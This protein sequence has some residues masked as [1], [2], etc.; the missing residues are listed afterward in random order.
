MQDNLLRVVPGGVHRDGR[1]EARV[2][3]GGVPDVSLVLEV[4]GLE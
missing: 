1:S 4:L 3:R 2:S